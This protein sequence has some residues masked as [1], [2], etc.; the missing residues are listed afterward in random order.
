MVDGLD[1]G[2]PVERRLTDRGWGSRV[3]LRVRLCFAVLEDTSDDR[4]LG[5]GADDAWFSA[6]SGTAADFDTEDA[7]EPSDP[8]H[9]CAGG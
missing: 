1:V 5:D 3:M 6:T 8:S 9:R 7:F 2:L 4:R